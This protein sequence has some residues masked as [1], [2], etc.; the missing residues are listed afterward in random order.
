LYGKTQ[1]AKRKTR[2]HSERS[3]GDWRFA[4][5]TPKSV[6]IDGSSCR[7][8]RLEGSELLGWKWRG[9]NFDSFDISLNRGVVHQV[10]GDL[11]TEASQ[12]PLP[13]DPDLAQALL[14]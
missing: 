11:K 4:D 13:L 7:S 3:Q 9:I 1:N 10:M 8:Y 6:Q 14:G 5:R 2:G 12:K